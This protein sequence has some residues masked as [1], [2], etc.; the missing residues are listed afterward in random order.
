MLPRMLSRLPLPFPAQSAGTA[1]AADAADCNAAESST[2]G[3]GLCRTSDHGERGS[4]AKAAPSCA[5]LPSRAQP[6]SSP[7]VFLDPPNL[8]AGWTVRRTGNT[9]TAP[10]APSAA[11]HFRTLR[12]HGCDSTNLGLELI[13]A[14]KPPMAQFVSPVPDAGAEWHDCNLVDTG[15][16]LFVRRSHP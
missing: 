7:G 6:V 9:A 15:L 3:N 10:S 8:H 13:G 16:E 5:L 11:D 14:S 1:D 12:R 4:T 2:I